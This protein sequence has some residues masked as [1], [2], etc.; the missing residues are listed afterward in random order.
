MSEWLENVEPLTLKS[1]IKIPCNW[2]V[3]EVGSR[4]LVSLR[5]D[6][7]IIG[8]RCGESNTVFV[9]PRMNC[10]KCFKRIN[11]WVDLRPEGIVGRIPSSVLPIHCNRR[12]LPFSHLISETDESKIKVRMKVKSIFKDPAEMEG[13]I[14]DIRYLEIIG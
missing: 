4:F 1:Q 8:N 14:Q 13:N 6:Q 10:G 2:S 7:K 3:G 11:D 12:T 9:P 5:D